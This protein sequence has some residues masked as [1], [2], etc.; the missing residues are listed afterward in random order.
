[1]Q[2]DS[3]GTGV[4]GTPHTG[5]VGLISRE[6]RLGVLL[7]RKLDAGIVVSVLIMKGD[8]KETLMR[9]LVKL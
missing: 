2:E 1:M 6:T 4:G 3:P 5:E 8:V 7:D 9:K